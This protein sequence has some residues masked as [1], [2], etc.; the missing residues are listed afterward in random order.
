[1]L[2]LLLVLVLLEA[3]FS[4]HTA[5]TCYCSSLLVVHFVECCFCLCLLAF[6]EHASQ[7]VKGCSAASRCD[8]L[9]LLSVFRFLFALLC[10]AVL[11]L[12]ILGTCLLQRSFMS[13]SIQCTWLCSPHSSSNARAA[14]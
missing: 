6:A 14:S 3:A 9:V 11:L 10:L 8:F 2:V 13:A 7:F 5:C 12:Q 4:L 1:M